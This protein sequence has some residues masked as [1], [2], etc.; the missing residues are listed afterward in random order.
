MSAFARRSYVA[1][2]GAPLGPRWAAPHPRPRA[3]IGPSDLIHTTPGPTGTAPR[4]FQPSWRYGKIS[5][6]AEPASR[7]LS[8]SWRSSRVWPARR[9]RSPCSARPPSPRPPAAPPGPVLR[10]GA[11]LPMTGPGAW[12]GAEIKQGLDLAAPSSIR[13]GGRGATSTSG[14]G[15]PESDR[16]GREARRTPKTRHRDPAAGGRRLPARRGPA[17]PPPTGR[18]EDGAERAR[19]RSRSSRRIDQRTLPSSSRRSTSSRST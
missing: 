10:L 18:D 1:I 3:G 12:F 4:R 2:A 15:A 8:P 11:L 13:A 5:L 9:R 19:R 6:H 16:D 14:G 7:G 17:P